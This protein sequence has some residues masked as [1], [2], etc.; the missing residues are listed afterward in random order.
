MCKNCKKA[1][2]AYDKT[3]ALASEAYDNTIA[4]PWEAY[5]KARANCED[6]KKCTHC[7]R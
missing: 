4:P 5:E 2:T 1:W 6:K 7:G 3:M